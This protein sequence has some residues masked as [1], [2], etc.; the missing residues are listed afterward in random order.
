MGYY[1]N[2]KAVEKL[3]EKLFD[4]NEISVAVHISSDDVKEH[5]TVKSGNI[6][7]ED[8]VLSVSEGDID[9]TVE[10]KEEGEFCYEDSEADNH[11]FQYTIENGKWF[12]LVLDFI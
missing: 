9:I 11:Y 2:E 10:M 7:V 3:N 4:A 1:S 8:H 12:E 5:F 6:C